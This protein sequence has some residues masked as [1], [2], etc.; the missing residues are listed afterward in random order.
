LGNA[1]GGFGIRGESHGVVGVLGITYA[2][3]SSGVYGYHVNSA[4]YGELG[5]AGFGVFGFAKGGGVA[6]VH[7]QHDDNAGLFAGVEG[8]DVSSGLIG[9]LGGQ[10]Y[11]VFSHGDI[12]S[13]GGKSFVEPH[14]SDPT[15]EINYVCLE[16]PESGTYF[17]GRGKIVNGFATIDV[18]DHFRMVTA[19]NG[20]TVVA[21]PIGGLAV[22]AAVHQ[23]LDKIVIQGSSD[24]EFNYMVNG[25]RKAFENHEPIVPNTDFIPRS[26][27]DAAYW[28]GLPPESLRRMK[29]NGTLNP[30]GSI[31]LETA[32]RLGWDR[33]P[34]W[35]GPPAAARENEARK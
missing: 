9:Y 32:H 22:L 28:K 10:T 31:N 7:G 19:E 33:K 12:K 17:R 25:V 16:G 6:G 35:N 11:G 27:S 30:D 15:K 20:L 14:S 5:G 1:V 3:S 4:N 18:P 23:G 29:A 21:T 34:E 26:P 8:E 13:D 2:A 24:V